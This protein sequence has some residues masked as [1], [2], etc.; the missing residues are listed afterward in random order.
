[1]ASYGHYHKILTLQCVRCFIRPV[2]LIFCDNDLLAI[3]YPILT[4]QEKMKLTPYLKAERG[5]KLCSTV[6]SEKYHAL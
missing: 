1:M 4:Q 3:H 5:W 6:E 2:G